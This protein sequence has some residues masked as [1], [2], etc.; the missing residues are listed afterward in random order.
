MRSHRV[1]SPNGARDDVFY[2]L[3]DDTRTDPDVLSYLRAENQYTEA[4][5]TPIQPMID[6][7]YTDIVARLIQDDSTVP[8]RYHG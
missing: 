6:G 4:V 3:R 2:W 7:L 1:A 5:L 8:V